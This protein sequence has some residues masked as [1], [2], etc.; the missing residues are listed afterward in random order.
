MVISAHAPK[1]VII[2]ITVINLLASPFGAL[3]NQITNT[4][5]RKEKDILF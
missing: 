1:K 3:P 5:T 4:V 2:I